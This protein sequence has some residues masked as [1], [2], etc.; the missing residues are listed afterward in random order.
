MCIDDDVHVL[1]FLTDTLE[2][3]GYHVETAV[4]GAH[5][6]Q[7][8]ALGAQPYNLIIVDARMPHLDGWRFI[9][10]AR[11]GGYRGKIIVFSGHLD[12]HE[13]QRYGPLEIDRI[14]EKPPKPGELLLAI[15]QITAPAA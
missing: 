4:D 3:E 15:N 9:V 1:S 10:Q 7:K 12:E 14:I 8:V 11:A 2:S 13:R 5:A 6:L